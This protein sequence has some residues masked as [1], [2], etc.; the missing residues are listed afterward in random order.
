M[1]RRRKYLKRGVNKMTLALEKPQ[2]TILTQSK[3]ELLK[4][5]IG[6]YSSKIDLNKIRSECK[7]EKN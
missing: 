3:K 1:V 4:G 7:N 2:K 6:K 5:I